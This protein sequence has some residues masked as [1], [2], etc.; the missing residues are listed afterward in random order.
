MRGPCLQRRRNL[1]Q[2]E[3]VEVAVVTEVAVETSAELG[4]TTGNMDMLVEHPTIRVISTNV[5]VEVED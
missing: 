1:K 4:V 2:K 5:V 3:G